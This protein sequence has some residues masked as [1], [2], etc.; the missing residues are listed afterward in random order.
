MS[1]TISPNDLT[2][3]PESDLEDLIPDFMNNRRTDLSQ[4]QNAMTNKD[5]VFIKR[6]GH[7]LKG[8]SRPYGFI[9]L[10]TI[11][12]R[13]EEAGEHQDLNQVQTLFDEMKYYLDNVKIVF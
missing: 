6:L 11:S 4:I 7:T 13:L 5:F 8:I 2:V 3:R 1:P 10:E 9:Y 12:K